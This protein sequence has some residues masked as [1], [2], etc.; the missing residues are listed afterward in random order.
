MWDAC[1]AVCNLASSSKGCQEVPLL[2]ADF[3]GILKIFPLLPPKYQDWRLLICFCTGN[4]PLSMGKIIPGTNLS[5]NIPDKA[6][7]LWWVWFRPQTPATNTIFSKIN[8]I[9]AD[10]IFY[11][12]YLLVSTSRTKLCLPSALAGCCCNNLSGTICSKWPRELIIYQEQKRHFGEGC[13]Y[14]CVVCKTLES[15]GTFCII[16]HK[17]ERS[18]ISKKQNKTKQKEVSNSQIC[19][20]FLFPPLSFWFP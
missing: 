10:F 13:N 16:Q 4:S 12:T 15:N 5:T 11:S 7:M 8:L 20:N 18:R 17:E 19:H 14:I 3:R 2:Q 1:S 6:T 9:I